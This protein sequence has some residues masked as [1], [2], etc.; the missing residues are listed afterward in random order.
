VGSVTLVTPSGTTTTSAPQGGALNPQ[1][2]AY[3]YY[4]ANKRPEGALASSL[5]GSVGSEPMG[6]SYAYVPDA[7]EKEGVVYKRGSLQQSYDIGMRPV[8]SNLV[9]GGAGTGEIVGKE[10]ARR[11]VALVSSRMPSSF[12]PVMRA[13]QLVNVESPGFVGETGLSVTKEPVRTAKQSDIIAQ[14]KAGVRQQSIEAGGVLPSG[15]GIVGVGKEAL[16]LEAG[17]KYSEA[18]GLGLTKQEGKEAELKQL[19]KEY[20]GGLSKAEREKIGTGI[21]KDYSKKLAQTGLGVEGFRSMA[22]AVNPDILARRKE[23]AQ[24]KENIQVVGLKAEMDNIMNSYYSSSFAQKLSFAKSGELQTRF[25][26]AS[27][28]Y[29]GLRPVVPGMVRTGASLSLEAE[30]G[31]AGTGWGSPF[32]KV[33]YALEGFGGGQLV[34]AG[35]NP[36]EY[37]GKFALGTAFFMGAG[38]LVGGIAGGIAGASA[39]GLSV[40]GRVVPGSVRVAK[41]FEYGA[42]V[43]SKVPKPVLG[44][45][46]VVGTGAGFTGYQYAVGEI[47]PVYG[48]A[49]TFV[50]NVAMISALKGVGVGVTKTAEFGYKK[51]YVP[52]EVTKTEFGGLDTYR[53]TTEFGK[54]E[55]AVQ[56]VP[57]AMFIQTFSPSKVGAWLGFK[58]FERVYQV[59]P[60]PVSE[61]GKPGEA[62]T[63]M[64]GRVGVLDKKLGVGEAK[65]EVVSWDRRFSQREGSYVDLS[66]PRRFEAGEYERLGL[67]PQYGSTTES[68][69]KYIMGGKTEVN[70]LAYARPKA[71]TGQVQTI[72]VKGKGF[73]GAKEGFESLGESAW[74]FGK[75]AEFGGL[76]VEVGGKSWVEGLKGQKVPKVVTQTESFEFEVLGLGKTRA[77]E[78]VL[79]A[80]Q[81]RFFRE[82]GWPFG[83]PKKGG[84]A[85]S[86][87]DLTARR[88]GKVDLGKGKYKESFVVTGEVSPIL[89]E[90]I[91]KTP[92]RFRLFVGK[93]GQAGFGGGLEGVTE[94]EAGFVEPVISKPERVK[95]EKEYRPER[96][97]M[98]IGGSRGML[99]A[100]SELRGMER[101]VPQIRPMLLPGLTKPSVISKPEVSFMPLRNVISLPEISVKP[102]ISIVPKVE[103]SI[104][105]INKDIQVKTKIPESRLN[106]DIGFGTPFVPPPEVPPPEVPFGWPGGLGEWGEGG[107]KAGKTGGVKKGYKPSILAIELGLSTKQFLKETGGLGLRPLLSKRR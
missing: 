71:K 70:V 72:F 103:E 13:D 28:E 6:K 86:R 1:A 31:Y 101:V 59:T 19:G 95:V 25:E 26:K 42:G 39:T 32:K 92:G 63:G 30:K 81:V 12:L 85:K 23:Q 9:I 45:V 36:Y 88:V 53:I 55:R 10:R 46:E 52:G 7:F 97:E 8:P 16:Y 75:E 93:K 37:A 102:E 65:Y 66:K 24:V 41:A 27:Q 73:V 2:E 83:L 48:V 90:I 62:G 68:L 4:V 44:A 106:I 47:S 33:G 11:E 22:L 58:P 43:I 98:D 89:P 79:G 5:P 57:E 21:A 77:G 35:R 87:V 56:V 67:L 96:V 74:E 18:Y 14:Y 105:N 51:M 100:V 38:A 50:Q 60:K 40:W 61:L 15:V 76:D 84:G 91:P 34:G 20:I 82:Q 94:L 17:K 78:E 107:S 54:G 69:A 29:Y 64:I 49:G 99:K 104:I 3:A 80:E